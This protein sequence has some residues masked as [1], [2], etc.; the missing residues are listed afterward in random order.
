MKLLRVLLRACWAAAPL[1]SAAE[2]SSQAKLDE[3]AVRAVQALSIFCM[4][5]VVT[6]TTKNKY[7]PFQ[8]YTSFSSLLT[9]SLLLF[10]L[11]IC[12]GAILSE[13]AP[14]PPHVEEENAYLE[15]AQVDVYFQYRPVWSHQPS[16]FDLSAAVALDSPLN[17]TGAERDPARIL[18]AFILALELGHKDVLNRLLK[19]YTPAPSA[20]TQY[21]TSL[22][23]DGLGRLAVKL[24]ERE[25]ALLHEVIIKSNVADSHSS[26]KPAT[27][28][29]ALQI[30]AGHL[31]DETEQQQPFNLTPF[32][33]ACTEGFEDIVQ[34]YIEDGRIKQYEDLPYFMKECLFK[35]IAKE[36]LG[37]IRQLVRAFN[38]EAATLSR[39]LEKAIFMHSLDVVK[40]MVETG[41]D[42]IGINNK[43]FILTCER[44]YSDI[45][46]YLFS[47]EKVKE[48]KETPTHL[49]RYLFRTED[50]AKLRQLFLG[51]P[52]EIPFP[53]SFLSD[54]QIVQS[55]GLQS[56][57]A[58]RDL[59][60]L[61]ARNSDKMAVWY[62]FYHAI[63]NGW[64]SIVKGYLAN[65][66]LFDE[67]FI[68]GSLDPRYAPIAAACGHTETA[69][70][71]LTHPRR[72]RQ[73][74]FR[75]QFRL[76]QR[77][78]STVFVTDDFLRYA[79]SSPMFHTHLKYYLP[80]KTLRRVVPDDAEWA[81]DSFL[82]ASQHTYRF[83]TDMYDTRECALLL[84][85]FDK[86]AG[87]LGDAKTSGGKY[88]N[89]T[90]HIRMVEEMGR[91]MPLPEGREMATFKEHLG[92]V[93][94]ALSTGRQSQHAAQKLGELPVGETY[95][96]SVDSSSHT[97]YAIAT[98]TDDSHLDVKVFNSYH[99][100]VHEGEVGKWRRWPYIEWDGLPLEEVLAKDF[101]ELNSNAFV[102]SDTIT[103][104][105]PKDLPAHMRTKGQRI[106]SCAG[107]K[108]WLV[109]RH[110]LETLPR[111]LEFSVAFHLAFIEDLAENFDARM[112]EWDAKM[113]RGWLAI[114]RTPHF[115]A[116]LLKDI[117]DIE[118]EDQ[119]MYKKLHDRI[120]QSVQRRYRI[121][122]PQ[123]CNWA[124]ANE[125][126]E[127]IACKKKFLADIPDEDGDMKMGVGQMTLKSI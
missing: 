112:R 4:A 30:I 85:F 116:Q 35:T 32:L 8:M 19:V 82:R 20:K 122:Y 118:E 50:V 34:A 92:Q 52:P 110:D 47:L 37:V 105:P 16:P 18:S 3:F 65:L 95:M 23:Q 78:S 66:A 21:I 55:R 70:A 80:Y 111:F 68:K 53:P 15:P 93:A 73:D 104:H 77:Y 54:E 103:P 99:K 17:I 42:P 28:H 48:H 88:R 72:S 46:W 87:L 60:A 58:D 1:L 83:H 113:T 39:A 106:G 27:I 59:V 100:A 2:I 121:L 29:E 69:L 11:G 74:R 108:F 124:D 125:V 25:P 97:G 79:R 51:D 40:I 91:R 67:W 90:H 9:T 84:L 43:P 89:D 22:Y 24:T 86:S 117:K 114:T 41:V 126:A 10:H 120:I 107:F 45:I 127:F 123:L 63:I 71:L 33:V 76:L 115:E 109:A 62:P 98:K 81:A 44:E 102:L 94:E 6:R 7:Y 31:N 49:L 36:H 119:D 13:A 5:L 61:L 101:G 57:F 26:A 96:F 75:L 12:K 64:L 14:K 56:F 38:F